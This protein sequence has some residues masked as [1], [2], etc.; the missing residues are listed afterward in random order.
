MNSILQQIFKKILYMYSIQTPDHSLVSHYLYHAYQCPNR[1][2]GD[3]ANPS[4]G[5]SNSGNGSSI[6]I[7]SSA[8]T[9]EKVT[10][11]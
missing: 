3:G 2:L 1:S 7:S 10:H 8:N 11:R 5:V 9:T 4:G 6:A